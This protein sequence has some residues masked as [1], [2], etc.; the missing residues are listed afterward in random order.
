MVA[1]LPSHVGRILF[2]SRKGCTRV[3]CAAAYHRAA[4]YPRRQGL[5]VP[6]RTEGALDLDIR[7]LSESPSANEPAAWLKLLSKNVPSRYQSSS[8]LAIYRPD[9]IAPPIDAA[10][11][12]SIME[13][14]R[15]HANVDLLHFLGPSEGRWRSLRWM[16]EVLIA[17]S[18]G[19]SE[20]GR[21][22][23]KR[24]STTVKEHDFPSMREL[25]NDAISPELQEELLISSPNIHPDEDRSL[26]DRAFSQIWQSLGSLVLQAECRRGNKEAYKNIMLNV[27]YALGEMH[28]KGLF[29]KTIYN[30]DMA[31]DSSAVQRPPT[32]WLLSSR[33]MSQLS[34][35]AW[36]RQYL[37]ALAKAEEQG[38]EVPVPMIQPSFQSVG[39]ET[40]LELI[41][42]ACV[43][44]G[45][46]SEAAWIISELESSGTQ[47]HK[48]WSVIDWPELCRIRPPTLD[49]A[50]AL[51]LQLDRSRLDQ[52]TGISIADGDVSN[53]DMGPRTI[54]V[55]VVLAIVDG[56][57][58]N[59]GST[60][61]RSSTSIAKIQGLIV[62][63][64]R[65]FERSGVNFDPEFMNAVLLRLIDTAD[66]EFKNNPHQLEG[67]VHLSP[68]LENAHR[69]N[70]DVLSAIDQSPI[71]PS[72]SVLGY[73][74]R[75][76]EVFAAND[77]A[78]GVTRILE[79]IS[80]VHDA[81]KNIYIQEFAKELRT[82]GSNA[83]ETHSTLAPKQVPL[84][85]P[86]VPIHVLDQLIKFVNEN[87]LP[88]LGDFLFHGN[89]I[90][91]GFVQP[92][93]FGVPSLQPRLLEYAIGNKD[94]AVLTGVLEQL[95]PP[96]PLPILRALVEY[97]VSTHRWSAVE[98]IFQHLSKSSGTAWT[99]NQVMT[100]A[101][102]ILQRS[103]VNDS[104][105]GLNAQ[106]AE[107]I[108]SDALQGKYDPPRDPTRPVDL[109]RVQLANQIKRILRS[110]PGKCFA[111]L[112]PD[113]TR[114]KNRLSRTVGIPSKA[115][116]VLLQAVVDQFGCHAGRAM[117]QRWCLAPNNQQSRSGGKTE[118]LSVGVL[119][120]KP[121]VSK[122]H[123]I[124]T[125][126][127]PLLRT[128]AP[129]EGLELQQLSWLD[130]HGKD[131]SADEKR[132]RKAFEALPKKN[133]GVLRWAAAMSR[134]PEDNTTP[135]WS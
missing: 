112:P 111:F 44:G 90:E 16:I 59:P 28:H 73:L 99:A 69:P 12:L 62:S 72:A 98:E 9:P 80:N 84:L 45:W 42:W 60:S 85:H 22:Q 53:V 110:V 116:G 97:Y 30:Y 18:E 64:K 14:G 115:F 34:D 56:L 133:Q 108:L 55:E 88:G 129:E 126:V 121:V 46:I 23:N 11:F 135:D 33:I 5:E 6:S 39:T 51:R 113:L 63:C 123:L 3:Q 2:A 21:Y 103:N 1:T 19:E 117:W 32:L 15:T 20:S 128:L 81:N 67:L 95:E 24:T 119:D 40:W 87:Q 35:V 107:N 92:N 47:A 49:W 41:L 89:E 61:I 65:L 58:N 131:G 114:E 96:F 124:R 68:I 118:R 52:Y 86:Q 29:P 10:N 71:D 37:D 120:E 50:A 17:E 27:L 100:I 109:S 102:Y 125:I 70:E 122:R 130:G 48:D 38:Y 43:E 79:S 8:P 7:A 25:T 26:R 36:N 57:V 82:R 105:E 127:R 4:R 106:K 54:S 74:Y 94:D 66:L 31:R 134:G 132:Y 13:K 75:N 83:S 101:S 77:N 93:A 78:A 104:E 76:L 91:G